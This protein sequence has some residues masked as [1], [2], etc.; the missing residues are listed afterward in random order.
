MRTIFCLAILVMLASDAPGAERR[1][2]VVPDFVQLPATMTLGPC[3]AVSV[4][5]QGQLFLFHRGQHPIV[6]LSRQGAY[7]RSW[8]NREIKTAH[9]LRIDGSGHLWVTDMGAHRVLKF[10]RQGKLLLELGTG[11]PGDGD[12]QFNKPTDVAFGP[13]GVFY[14]ADGYGNSR[15][16]KFSP[17][18][19]LI[20]KWGTRGK[21]RGE[22]HLPHSILVDGT[23]R[24][25]VGDR[26]NNRIQVFDADGKLLDI[27]SGFAPYG[28]AMSPAGELYV[29]DGRAN[30]VLRLN[31]EGN[32]IQRIGKEGTSPGEFKMP[33]MLAF[34][35]QGNLYVA[36]VDGRRLQKFSQK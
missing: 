9:G 2:T 24:V 32:V 8:G 23:G 11:K 15:V 18:G 21:G 35:A 20:G 33:H 36:E 17:N 27:W 10:N 14:V 31:A 4:D 3:A 1:F 30:Q 22:F 7:L 34:D 19:S 5:D 6:C 12:H 25:L 28:M 13:N 29:A 16:L 26:E